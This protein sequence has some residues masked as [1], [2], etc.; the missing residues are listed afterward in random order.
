MESERVRRGRRVWWLSC[1]ITV[2]NG[3]IVVRVSDGEV[4]PRWGAVA[5]GVLVIGA[6]VLLWQR[7]WRDRH[8]AL[9]IVP[10]AAWMIVIDALYVAEGQWWAEMGLAI[11][12]AILVCFLIGSWSASTTARKSL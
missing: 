4:F 10:L 8:A 1:G 2:I 3:A 7:A 9:A 5:G 11:A 12:A 6:V